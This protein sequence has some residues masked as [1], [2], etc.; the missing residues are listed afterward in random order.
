MV[1]SRLRLIGLRDGFG[2]GGGGLGVGGLAGV[3]FLLDGRMMIY[4][5]FHISSVYIKVKSQ[6]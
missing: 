3:L 2:G 6:E 1:G 5:A 4:I